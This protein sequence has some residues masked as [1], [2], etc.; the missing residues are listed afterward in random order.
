[1]SDP[2]RVPSPPP[3]EKKELTMEYRQ[4]RLVVIAAVSVCVM[5]F[6]T[7]LMYNR[8]NDDSN[9]VIAAHN[10]DRAMFEYMK[11][12]AVKNQKP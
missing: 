12:E 8:H 1:M 7:I 11:L 9:V 6:S 2:Y 3:I 4:F 10:A 5:L